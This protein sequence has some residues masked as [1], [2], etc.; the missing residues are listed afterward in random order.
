MSSLPVKLPSTSHV[1]LAGGLWLFGCSVPP[2][3]WPG[4]ADTDGSGISGTGNQDTDAADDESDESGTNLDMGGGFTCMVGIA[5]PPG[6]GDGVQ[7]EDEACD[8]GNNESGDGCTADC[9]CVEPGY[10][11][12]IPGQPCY[13]AAICGDG[14]VVVPEPCDDGNNENGDGCSEF[15]KIELGWDCAGDPSECFQTTCGDGVQE[16]AEAC[17][18]G[19]TVPFDGCS[20]T[21]QAEPDC[22]GS[23]G[24]SSECGDGLVI[25]E[26]CDDGNNT[27]GDGCSASCEIEAGFECEE[28]DSCEQINDE[29]VLRVPAIFRDFN[30]SH[31]DFE[32]LCDGLQEG[33][34]QPMLNDAGKPVLS[35]SPI[36]QSTGFSQWYTDSSDSA[37]IVGDVVLFDN[38]DG[39]FVNR[40]GP[41]GERWTA[42]E[43]PNWAANTVEEC[44][45]M[46]C[47]P[48][49]WNP[50]VGCTA[51][52]VEYDGQPFFFPV[53][54]HPDALDDTRHPA[55][56]G[57]A[58]GYPN[59]PYETDLVPEAGNHNFHFTTELVYWFQYDASTSA[60]LDFTGDDDVWVFVNGHL[61]LDLGGVHVPLSGVVTIDPTTE[62]EYEL[63]DGNV[64][65]ISVFHA[66]RRLDGSSFRLTLAGFSNTP[67]NCLAICGDGIV[68]LGE[69]C[70]DGINDGGYG[71]C[72]EGCVLGEYCGDGIVQEEEDCDDGNYVNG[73]ECPNGC[74]MINIP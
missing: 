23:G 35:A 48:C 72:G 20:S 3:G 58:Y 1:L 50:V 15:C 65:P 18:D 36:C 4:G 32:V 21:C 46:G 63:T 64:Y 39:S 13:Q 42:L 25:D 67:S 52:I 7:T 40:W 62:A 2:Q 24:C 17:D 54:G 43:N 56:I 66:E 19:N 27:N 47:V 71:E 49:P 73:D 28:D 69:Q 45:A 74:V 30:A 51:D 12:P 26:Q 53:D 38:G 37:T 11:C 6:C 14:I 61:A 31:S 9:L 68:G 70:D 16:G 44:E 22:S 33:G 59:W 41:E 60:Q 57:P 29:C 10:Q 5:T 34:V 55:R 8:D